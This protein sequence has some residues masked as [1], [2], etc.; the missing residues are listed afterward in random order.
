MTKRWL[1]IRF[2]SDLWREHEWLR[3]IYIET[4]W[5]FYQYMDFTHLLLGSYWRRW[6]YGWT[7]KSDSLRE[8]AV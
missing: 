8:A 6:G 1:F 5:V 7:P 3:V 4:P 2:E